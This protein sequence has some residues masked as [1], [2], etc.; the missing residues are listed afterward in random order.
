MRIRARHEWLAFDRACG[1]RGS[2]VR[3]GGSSHPDASRGAATGRIE[4]NPRTAG[5]LCRTDQHAAAA[6]DFQLGG[7]GSLLE[8]MFDCAAERRQADKERG[9]TEGRME[10]RALVAAS[11]AAAPRSG[12]DPV[13]TG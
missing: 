3:G 9:E 5:R 13:P 10:V 1:A 8:A 12:S 2:L 4:S 7:W 6:R 11:L